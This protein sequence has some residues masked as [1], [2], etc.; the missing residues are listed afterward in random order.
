MWLLD[1]L[2]T[3]SPALITA[4]TL[5]AA[6]GRGFFVIIWWSGFL[7]YRIHTACWPHTHTHMCALAHAYYIRHTSPDC[8]RKWPILKAIHTYY[9][10]Q[11]SCVD[12]SGIALTAVECNAQQ[13]RNRCW[14]LIHSFSRSGWVC[15]RVLQMKFHFWLHCSERFSVPSRLHKRSI[16][17]WL[18]QTFGQAA[19]VHLLPY[20]ARSLVSTSGGTTANIKP[21]PWNSLPFPRIHSA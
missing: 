8:L 6:L 9:T 16:I 7:F 10:H 5:W 13:R 18:P 12:Q 11:M 14:W 4:E 21:L 20:W 15:V 19:Q 1:W 17:L 3:N 2:V